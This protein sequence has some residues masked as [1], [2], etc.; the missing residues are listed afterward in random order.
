ME[1]AREADMLMVP[2]RVIIVMAGWGY[3]LEVVRPWGQEPCGE[4]VEW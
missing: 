3:T 1:R 4:K 2:L